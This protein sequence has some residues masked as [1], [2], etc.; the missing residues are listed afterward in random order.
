MTK[1]ENYKSK[2]IEEYLRMIAKLEDTL[3]LSE[4]NLI[5]LNEEN[6]SYLELIARNSTEKDDYVKQMMEM[7]DKSKEID[8]LLSKK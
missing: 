6:D 4:E 7:E 2:L 1:E 8:E 5:K 3:R